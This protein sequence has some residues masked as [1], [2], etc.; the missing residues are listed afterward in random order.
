MSHTV[1]AT[2][3]RPEEAERAAGAL[4]TQG[5]RPED[6]SVV[7]QPESGGMIVT[8]PHATASNV[9]ATDSVSEPTPALGSVYGVEPDPTDST[10]DRLDVAN[11]DVDEGPAMTGLLADV[12]SE[13]VASA[14]HA[15]LIGAGIG[16]VAALVAL[17]IPGVGVVLGAGALASALAGI[18]ASA[19]AG[20]AAGAVVALLKEHGV[21][22]DVA[23]GYGD[24]VAQ[25]GAVLAV[26]LPSGNVDEAQANAILTEHKAANVNRYASRGYVS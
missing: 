6:L 20:A 18:A 15:S 16:A 17:M 26:T 21:D 11:G 25:G 22:G 9:L 12:P 10:A 8:A 7:K 2:F 13:T 5:V 3:S 24:T 23:E 19:G 14:K 1:Y 4:L